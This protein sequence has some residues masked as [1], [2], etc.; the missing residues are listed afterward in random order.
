VDIQPR[1]GVRYVSMNLATPP[2]DD[3]HVRRAVAFA[4]DRRK[5][6]QAFGGALTGSV[7][8]HLALD[9]MEDNALINYDP[10][11]TADD[12]T[13]LQMA[14]HEMA[15]SKYDSHQAGMCDAAACQHVSGLALT[16]PQTPTA[17]AD[18]VRADLAQIGIHID[19]TFGEGMPYFRQLGDPMK[20]PAMGM[21]WGYGKDYPNGADF[22]VQLFSHD[23][24]AANMDYTLVGASQD[25]LRKW[26]YTVSSVPNVDDRI[27][28]C[29]PLLGDAQT[30]CWTSLDQ[31]MIE[32]VAA[33]VPFAAETYTEL[34]PKRVVSYSYD[35]Y[36][37]L[38]ALDRIALQP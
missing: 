16:T 19:V 5:L 22:F 29:L 13:R 2:F 17:M 36:V 24:I 31:Y 10:Y 4:I 15:Q 27:A 3:L 12:A 32:R 26:G 21:F 25:Q 28:Q 23:A 11:R 38:P 37:T 35:Q 1:D 14:R 20:D 18:V 7:T 30:R 9:S 33:V 6:E 8:G 34:V